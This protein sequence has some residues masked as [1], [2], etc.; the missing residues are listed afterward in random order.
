MKSVVGE[1]SKF[2]FKL[3]KQ[4]RDDITKSNPNIS[5]SDLTKK[6]IKYVDDNKS[7]IIAEY[8]KLKK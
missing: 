3:A 6:A 5:S 7:K 8:N 4:V 1:H 2:L